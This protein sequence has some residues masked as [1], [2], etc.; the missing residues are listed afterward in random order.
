MQ[1]K[2]QNSLRFRCYIVLVFQTHFT[3][4]K[5]L[6]R[7]AIRIMITFEILYYCMQRTS[8]S[9]YKDLEHLMSILVK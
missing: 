5:F 8:E 1:R 4:N 9:P 7:F 2:F 3:K 6:S